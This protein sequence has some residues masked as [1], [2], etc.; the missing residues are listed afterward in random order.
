MK[1]LFLFAVFAFLGVSA[2]QQYFDDDYI[3]DLQKLVD[4]PTKMKLKG[5]E[6]NH[7]IPRTQK[8]QEFEQILNSQPQQVKDAFNQKMAYENMKRQ[9]KQANLQQ[10]M[11]WMPPAVS[12]AYKQMD[13]A[14]NDLSL[15]DMEYWTKKRQIWGGLSYMDRRQF[16]D[17][18]SGEDFD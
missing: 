9:Q 17:S 4:Y 3:D 5:L 12:D 18:S 14:K 1:S 7:Y 6:D 11:Q 16:D 2:Q 8:K 10:R 15:S 13:Q